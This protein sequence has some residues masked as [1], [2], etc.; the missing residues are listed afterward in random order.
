MAIRSVIFAKDE[1]YHIYNRGN[2]KRE[3]FHDAEDYNRLAGLLYACNQ[4]GNFSSKSLSKTEGL[5]QAK[6]VNPIVAIGAYCIMPNHFHL[7][8]TELGTGGISRFM[9]KVS[10]AYA[11]YYN[12]K[13]KRTGVLF[14]GKFKAKHCDSDEYLKYLFS[15]IHLN[16]VKLIDPR[17]KE[18][19]IKNKEESI[20][21]LK[22]YIHS[23]FL[24]YMGEES[25]RNKVINRALFPEY[26]PNK[27]MFLQE[28][29]NWMDFGYELR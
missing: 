22:N 9:Q 23:S 11:M 28:I 5:F 29:F 13:Y 12:K 26:F 21:Y 19:G 27:E 18:V 10:T 16:P 1:Y 17:W 14:E 2:G 20:H 4:E 8:V 6:V 24:D 7:I 3:I 15:Y 25:P